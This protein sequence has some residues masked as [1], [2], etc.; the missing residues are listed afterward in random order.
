MEMDDR[1]HS[2]R[3]NQIAA[4]M[5]RLR[6][7]DTSSA[8]GSSSG[9]GYGSDNSSTNNNN[10]NNNSKNSNSSK[11]DK[12]TKLNSGRWSSDEHKRF[13]AG[14]DRYGTGN[15]KK[16]TEMVG[17]R[18]CTQIRTHAQKYFIAL[19][20]PAS[21][22]TNADTGVYARK[23]SKML[24]GADHHLGTNAKMGSS[25]I[26]TGYGGGGTPIHP[27]GI[28]AAT[29]GI[30]DGTENGTPA[31]KPF[32]GPDG[33]R[34]N[35]TGMLSGMEALA[36]AAITGELRAA[37]AG[38]GA[39]KAGGGQLHNQ[40][41]QYESSFDTAVAEL[42]RQIANDADATA[43][44]INASG[45]KASSFASKS[46]AAESNLSGPIPST[47][48]SAATKEAVAQVERELKRKREE[49]LMQEVSEQPPA[50]QD[51]AAAIDRKDVL[52][53]IQ[54]VAERHEFI[55]LRQEIKSLNHTI[56]ELQQQSIESDNR[57]MEAITDRRVALNECKNLQ[58]INVQLKTELRRMVLLFE[59]NAALVA[60]GDPSGTALMAA[61][62]A[63]QAGANVEMMQARLK[64]SEIRYHSVTESLSRQTG[65]LTDQHRAILELNSQ[66]EKEREK[67]EKLERELNELKSK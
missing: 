42:R 57:V 39:S 49:Q 6:S 38:A 55:R 29:A 9:D 36:Q 25:A 2:D 19:Q 54:A 11:K 4:I 12:D 24:V 47:T 45:R 59:Q 67:S 26:I 48:T 60:G 65:V 53:K 62:A 17:T 10:S 33:L 3:K 40:F 37:E 1:S 13:L 58:E 66:L 20:K 22:P 30:G 32:W 35:N 15:W 31:I 46:M 21:D 5:G 27:N 51:T 43:D 63:S 44:A 23:K 56:L 14:L 61:A 41:N 50:P 18:S 64:E 34:D 16:I 7:V 8:D 52:D 28:V